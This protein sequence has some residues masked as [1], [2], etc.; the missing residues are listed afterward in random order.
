MNEKQAKTIVEQVEKERKLKDQNR[1]KHV[2]LESISQQMDDKKIKELKLIIRADSRG[3]VEALRESLNKLSTSEVAVNI[4]QAAAGAISEGDIKLAE[5]SDAIIIGF[6]V[7]PTTKA[8]KLADDVGVEIRT[9]N[10]IYHITEEIEK[11]LTGML[12]PEYRELYLG[13]IEIKKIFK[14]NKVGNVAGCVVVDG[15]V[16]PEASVR[17]LRDGIVVYEGKLSSLKR[18]QDDA[19][20][21]VA[22]QECGLG[23][24]NFNDIKEGDIVESF[25]MEEVKRTLR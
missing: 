10:V 13:R 19:K 9:H 12:D 18:F 2:T 25:T 24:E 6:H 20:E 21:V 5:A 1:K 3:S 15:K 7:R 22:G 4:I 11:A 17:I 23:I 8:M 16:K 14:V